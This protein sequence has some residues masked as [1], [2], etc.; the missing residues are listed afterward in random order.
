M[1]TIADHLSVFLDSKGGFK[2]GEDSN[3]SLNYA[4]GGYGNNFINNFEAFYGYDFISLTG[5]SF[6]KGSINLDYEIFK[7]HHINLAANFANVGDNIFEDGKW[8]TAP[9]YSGY[10]LGYGLETFIGPIELK[11]TW[12]PET[13][14]SIWFFNL[15]FWF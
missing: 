4:L 14:K 15:G 3:N 7:K 12:S 5:N 11:Y 1:F 13:K 6:V 9:D 8:I 2:I 10:A